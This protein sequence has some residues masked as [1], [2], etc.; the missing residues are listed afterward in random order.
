M[1]EATDDRLALTYECLHYL[2]DWGATAE[3]LL[4]ILAFPE[5]TRTRTV[6]R[7]LQ[8]TPLPDN[9]A[10]L[11]RARQ[12]VRIGDALHTT[13]PHN[14]AMGKIWMNTP[15][16]RLRNTTPLACLIDGDDDG[17]EAVLVQLDC[18]YYWDLTGSKS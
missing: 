15:N 4:T 13:F 11:K 12:V 3:Q 16:S 17:F 7:Y 18:S 6:R 9:A 1:N 8:G 5:G 10:V 14:A 2:V